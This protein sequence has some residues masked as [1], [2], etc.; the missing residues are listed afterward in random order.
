MKNF[1]NFERA[2]EGLTRAE[3]ELNTM[4]SRMA[5]EYAEL[6]FIKKRRQALNGID[7]AKTELRSWLRKNFP[8]TRTDAFASDQFSFKEFFEMLKKYPELA[9]D[10]YESLK[11]LLANMRAGNLYTMQID[12]VPELEEFIR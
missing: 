6:E 2:Y 7:V 9:R 1:R 4:S 8:T 12:C 3:K 5:T 11:A 10:N